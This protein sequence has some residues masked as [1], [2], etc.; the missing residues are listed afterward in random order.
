MENDSY[1]H[2]SWSRIRLYA[3]GTSAGQQSLWAL[4]RVQ[5]RGADVCR[6]P[7]V[8]DWRRRHSTG[9]VPH[10]HNGPTPNVA[11]G[12]TAYLPTDGGCPYLWNGN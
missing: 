10:L 12:R 5:P 11:P 6:R 1:A 4:L 3:G 7:V 2:L 8:L 9:P